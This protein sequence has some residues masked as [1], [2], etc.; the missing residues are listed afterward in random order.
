MSGANIWM[1][2]KGSSDPL[3]RMNVPYRFHKPDRT[4]TLLFQKEPCKSRERT[5]RK[6]ERRI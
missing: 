2:V 6:V 5:G 4:R 3:Q 1:F